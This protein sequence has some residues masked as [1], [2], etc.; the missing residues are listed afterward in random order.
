MKTFAGDHSGGKDDEQETG[1]RRVFAVNGV[2]FTVAEGE[3]FTLLGPSGCGKSTTLRSIAGLEDPDSGSIALQERML[4]SRQG[5]SKPVNV[6]VHERGLGMVFQSYAIWPHMTVFDNVAFPLQVRRRKDK[7]T[8][9]V[10]ESRVMR[11][12]E[13]MEL[14]K[15]AQRP[16][17]KLSGGQQQ[18]LALARAIVIEPPLLLLDEPLSNLDAKLRES[19]RDELKRL[20]REL[21]ITSIYV[22]HDQVEALALSSRIAVMQEGNIVQ[23]GRPREIYNSPSCKFVAEFIGTTNF[24]PGVVC[25]REGSR[26]VV[27]T[28][29]GELTLDSPIDVPVGSDVVVSAR[30]EVID[31]HTEGSALSVANEWKGTVLSRSFLGDS[32]DHLV[33]VGEYTLRARV[34]PSVSIQPQS[35][36]F[37]RM[38]ADRLTMMAA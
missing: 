5:R 7:L 17:T 9:K 1:S 29:A 6:A 37:I 20:Q 12:L 38:S 14:T 21:G 36:V 10:I 2:S 24:L 23:L 18:R 3:L 19:L 27:R 34:N 30:P 4:F 32:V 16:A 26:Y 28:S 25:L 8:R 33:G 15:Y 11:V 22:T 35:Q 13:T 31:L